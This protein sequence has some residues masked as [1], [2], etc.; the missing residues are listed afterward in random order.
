[1]AAP[2]FSSLTPAQKIVG[3]IDQQAN[4]LMALLKMQLARLQ[5]DVWNNPDATPDQIVATMGTGAAAH[6]NAATA[7]Q[8]LL[9]TIAPGVNTFTPPRAVTINADGTV[10]LA[11]APPS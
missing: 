10:T 4:G 3:Q 2:A 1:M 8:T 9:N 6:F 7:L 5:T 11:A